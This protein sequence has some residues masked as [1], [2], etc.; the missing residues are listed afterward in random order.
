MKK[1]VILLCSL[2]VPALVLGYNTRPPRLTVV[3]VIDQF[4][5]HYI[6]KL[7]PHLKHGLRYLLDNGVVYTN[8]FMPHAQAGTATGHAGLNTGTCAK[9]HGFVSNAWY[10]DGKKVTC[11]SDFSGDALVFARDGMHNFGRSP[12]R[13]MVDGLSDQCAL[14]TQPFS[15]FAVYS[16]S[17]KSR[18]AIGAAGKLGKA[19]WFDEKTGLF[20][21]SKAYFDSLPEWLQRFNKEN[22]INQN[23]S[24]IWRQM[25]P[26]S[27]RAY[28]FFNIDNY[29]YSR[30]ES[31]IHQTLPVCDESHKEKYHFFERSPQANQHIFDCAQTCI[32]QYVS[33]K[34]RDRLLLWVC[35]SPLDKLG[36][37]YGPHSME[38]ID[39]IYHLDKQI[40]RFMRQ[41]LRVIGKHEVVFAL[42]ADHGVM[43]IP[44]LLHEK[45]LTQARRIDRIELI[46]GINQKL[47]D[48]Y[49][50]E[51][52]IVGYK[53]QELVLNDALDELK[54][55]ERMQ[56]M[57]DIKWHAMQVPGIRN[58]WLF[59]ELMHLPTQPHTIEDHLK[60]QL[61]RGRSGSI[62]MQT[63]PYAMVTHWSEG[64][65]HKTPY[66]Y[67]THVPMIIFHPGK[68][69]RKYVRQRVVALQL[70]NTLAEILN[71][72]KPSAST[73]EILPDLFDPEYK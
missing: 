15:N 56:I 48:K 45:G 38:V 70:A 55:Q 60:K 20:T 9:D 71:V 24:F 16:I 39:M 35:L 22:D 68:F 25:Y 2:F 57:R 66:G 27:P 50:V 14:Q 43:P 51:N 5:Y 34:N 12:H 32:K 54:P 42:T 33:R 13:L 63:E 62:I 11:D 4:A 26:Q 53:C 72:P 1:Y 8:A 17:G 7:Y 47:K 52:A 37:K 61:F 19:V 29:D 49:D 6:N 69:E 36:H 31:M 59:D 21:S 73:Y 23:S 67:D 18:S 10:E 44:Q 65:Q 30:S 3:F 64:A 41:T 28:N 58:V 46:N 40:R